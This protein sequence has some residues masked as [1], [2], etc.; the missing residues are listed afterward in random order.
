METSTSPVI[1][2]GFTGTQKG[3]SSQ[4]ASAVANFLGQYQRFV[5]H[6]GLCIGADE[7]FDG[8]ARAA[9]GFDHMVIHPGAV[10]TT[11][12]ATVPI[13]PRDLMRPVLDP[14]IRNRTIAQECDVLLATP[15]EDHMVLRSGTWS[16]VR[17]ALELAKPVFVVIPNGAVISWM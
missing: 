13:W 12:R 6:H 3:M 4:Q 9:L 14:L 7:Q 16:T 2:I 1:D 8:L 11:K 10:Y 17:Y 5:G 15:K